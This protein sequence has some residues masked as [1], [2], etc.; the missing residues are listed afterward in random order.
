MESKNWKTLRAWIDS[1]TKMAR[2]NLIITGAILPIAECVF[3]NLL[4]GSTEGKSFFAF[5]LFILAAVHLALLLIQLLPS[6]NFPFQCIADAVE[7]E[8]QVAQL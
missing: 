4:T 8:K 1:A 7:L 6:S 2:F 3:V 5:G